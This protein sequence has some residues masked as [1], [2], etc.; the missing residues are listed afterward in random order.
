VTG[1]D[2][3]AVTETVA[4]AYEPGSTSTVVPALAA[5]TAA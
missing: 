5:F 2:A 4:G 1:A 3:V